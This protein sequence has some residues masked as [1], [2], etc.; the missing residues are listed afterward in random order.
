M[1]LSGLGHM[2][3]RDAYL[4]RLDHAGFDA[5]FASDYANANGVTAVANWPPAANGKLP[6]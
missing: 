5:I 2:D 1:I 4:R 6:A 3:W